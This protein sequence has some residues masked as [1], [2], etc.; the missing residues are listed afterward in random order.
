ME[1]LT[2]ERKPGTGTTTNY[3]NIEKAYKVKSI[4][5]VKGILKR[6]PNTSGRKTTR[7]AHC[8]FVSKVKRKAGLS[9]TKFKDFPIVTL[10][11][12]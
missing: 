9:P 6:A 11:K 2:I 12:I 7:L 5:K 10:L 3:R 8:F 4:L 1:H